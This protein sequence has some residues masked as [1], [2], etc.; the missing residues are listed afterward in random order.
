MSKT[1][2]LIVDDYP[3]NIK[4]LHGLISQENIEVFTS[5]SPDQ[6][7]KLLSENDFGLALIDVE[8]PGMNGFELARLIRGVNRHKHL[9]IIFVTAHQ[10]DQNFVFEGYDS[11]AVDILFK[12]LDSYIVK[13]KVRA[14]VELSEQR[15]LL[16]EQVLELD[17]LRHVAESANSAKTQFL[18]NMSHEIRT[19]LAAVMGFADQIASSD[20]PQEERKKYSD[21]IRR[22]G[23]LLL[24][25]IDDILDLSKIES[26][27]IEFE[28]KNFQLDELL[29][30]VRAT[31]ASRAENKNIELK[32]ENKIKE[33]KTYFA[34]DLRIKQILINLIGNSIKFTKTGGVQ[35]VVDLAHIQSNDQKDY[36]KIIVSD[37]GVGMT[38]NQIKNIFKPFSQGDSSMRRQFGG[39]GLGLTISRRL[40]NALDGDIIV[41]DSQ[42]GKGSTFEITLGLPH[43]EKKL[44]SK[45]NNT[46]K[47]TLS[48]NF[49]D[50]NI[51]AVDDVHDNLM[52]LRLYLQDTGAKLVEAQN[53]PESIA[54]VNEKDFDLILMDVQMPGM[55]GRET[56]RILRQKGFTNP[57]V[58]LT[59]HAEASEHNKCYQAGCD[60]VLTKPINKSKLIAEIS[61]ILK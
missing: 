54:R 47:E 48:G 12:P 31:M 45:I 24:R 7:L 46:K 13:T 6:A 21:M 34:D 39:S 56:T 10:Q 19:P 49:D 58:A 2:V 30:D 32:I 1:K 53:G 36:L 60:A 35:V 44:D 5:E 41:L 28:D 25:L 14:F 15:I 52:L 50:L 38:Q 8:M 11:G 43:S 57:I 26:N 55:D 22:N 18:A 9:P 37:T 4:A 17:R 40:A 27:Q 23:E 29:S 3:E 16:E 61:N 20:F 42:P 51:L 33:E 59:A